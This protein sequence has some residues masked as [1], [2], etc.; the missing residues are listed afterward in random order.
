[1]A[2]F[3]VDTHLFRELGELLVG[4][5]STALVELIKNAYDADATDV[6]VYGEALS[7]LNRGFIR[8]KDNGTGMSLREFERG[9]LRIASRTKEQNDRRSPVFSRRYTGAKGIGRLNGT[10]QTVLG[11]SFGGGV[12]YKISPNWSADLQYLYNSFKWQTN[13]LY[14]TG[15][16]TISANNNSSGISIAINY[17]WPI[18]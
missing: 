18:K 15:P 7:S 9:F 10:S 16:Q 14:V 6:V 5:D 17:I 1:M 3:T 13:L 4:R 12:E 2:T 11:P 8:I